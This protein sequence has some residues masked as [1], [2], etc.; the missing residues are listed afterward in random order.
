MSR[1]IQLMGDN[2]E[3]LWNFPDEVTD[4]QIETWCKE[5]LNQDSEDEYYDSLDEFMDK[6]YPEVDCNRVFVD[7][8]YL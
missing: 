5:Y 4:E 2:I 1:L 8:I 3:E 6:K 7:E